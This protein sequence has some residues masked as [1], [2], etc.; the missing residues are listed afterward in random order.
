M[1]S[2]I[3]TVTIDTSQVQDDI[4]KLGNQLEELSNTVKRLNEN[5][6]NIKLNIKL[7]SDT[8]LKRIFDK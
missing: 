8:F 7:D 6:I 5:G 4:K 1:P 2:P 3:A